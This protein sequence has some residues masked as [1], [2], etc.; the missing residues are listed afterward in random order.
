MPKKEEGFMITDS[1]KF[2][3]K[4]SKTIKKSVKEDK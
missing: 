2:R 1:I 4:I 3:K